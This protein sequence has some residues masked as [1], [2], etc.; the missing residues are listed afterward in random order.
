MIEFILGTY[1]SGKTTEIFKRIADDTA[2]GKKCFLIIPDQEAVQFERLSLSE[3]PGKSQLYLEILSF[4]RLYN[5]VCREYGGLSYSYVT[6]PMRSLI[7]WKSLRDL[8]PLL[9][10]YGSYSS[11]DA[12]LSDLMLSA[13]GEFKMSGV[14]ATELERAASKLPNDS[15]LARRLYDL[16]LIYSCYDNFVNEKY[17]D[18]ADDLSRL[19]DILREHRFFDG[20]S[21]YIDSFT[22]FTAVQH[23]VIDQIFAT[24]DTT[25]ITVP[26]CSYEKSSISSDS[27]MRSFKRLR[28]SAE[29][30][31][32]A[33]ELILTENRRTN[34]PAI[35]YLSKNLWHLEKSSECNAPD[36]NGSIVAEICSNPY[37]EA[38]AVA[39][40][41]LRLLKD[42]A[43]CRDIVIVMRDTEKYRGI[44]EPALRNSSIPFFISEKADLCATAAVKFI[45]SAL[46][47]KRYNWRTSDVISHIKTGL[48]DID[49]SDANL[50]EEYVTM[51]SISGERF[52]A[53]TWTMNP[54]G[55]VTE[56][57]PR[58]EAILLAANRVRQKLTEPLVKLFVMLDAAEN[59]AD[60]CRALYTYLCGVSLEDKLSEASLKAAERGDLKQARELSR[61]YEVIL[62]SLADTAELLG[63]EQ[64]DDEEFLL[65]LKTVFDK[66]EIGSI[67][68][69]IDEVTVGS[70][71][72]LRSANQKYA[73]VMGLCEGEFPAAVS[74]NG[75]FSAGDIQTLGELGIELSSDVDTRSSDELMYVERAFSIPSERLYIFTH[76]AQI[77]GGERFP[78][79]AFK[80]VEKLFPDFKPHIYRSDDFDY[81]VPAPRNAAGILRSIDNTVL[82]DS[83]SEAL[84]EYIPGISAS[85]SVSTENRSCHISAPTLNNIFG[86]TIYFSPSS[87]EKYV[88]CP[89][90]YYCDKI[91]ELREPK[92]AD[93]RAN[94]MGTFIHFILEELLKNSI[95]QEID[96]KLVDGETIVKDTDKAVNAYIESICPSYLL[97]S[98]R[99]KHLYSRLRALSLL[100]IENIVEEFSK[101]EFRPVFFELSANGCGDNPSPLVFRL[102]DGTRVSFGGIVDRVDVFK[103]GENVY[104]RVVDYKTGTKSFCIDDISYGMNIQMLLY[105][106]TLCRSDS[107]AFKKAIDCPPDSSPIPAGVIYLSAN[108]PLID[109][110]DYTQPEEVLKNAAKELDRTGILTDNEDI[111]RAM[112]RDL[113]QS[114]IAGIKRS[115]KDG[116]LTGSALTGAQ[117]FSEIY[118]KLEE[119]IVKFSAEL[120]SG[121]ADARPLQ[122]GKSPCEY[123]N[124]RPICRRV[125]N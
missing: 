21:V 59:I 81:L 32:Q 22:S 31:G 39:A 73:I 89:F 61:I 99:M 52:F 50:F 7:M 68:T 72:M 104:L 105:L 26:I 69:S 88:K 102:A 103:Q 109:T 24:A 12:T 98:K 10:E 11:A 45:L 3:L 121:V 4:S 16:S 97:E 107:A 76:T 83:L 110:D 42:G 53:D 75:I 71:A 108:I 66:T 51:W 35:S 40:H 15:I 92:T 120:R 117:K 34:V 47:I 122:Y 116:V 95:P 17:S 48:C 37:S 44:I 9:M 90:N 57:S 13:I 74:D 87:F 20:A 8:S 80:R 93:F 41:I 18:S 64:V 65:I 43:R 58:A 96:T 79:L 55:F 114:F 33:Q 123:C 23:K 112:N 56:R 36:V 100:L 27:I 70:A 25:V 119:V 84:E 115:A 60:M 85:S 62:S 54:D 19:N 49:A 5:R 38:E 29:R 1:G 86:D 113:D 2:K 46:K 101:S 91:L 28:S 67:P 94:D 78:S 82:K 14:S 63:D 30:Y 125:N 118:E 6:D 111:L 106:F 77:G 124:S